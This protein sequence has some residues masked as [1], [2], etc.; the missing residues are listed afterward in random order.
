MDLI[1]L[2]SNPHPDPD[3]FPDDHYQTEF[4]I[5][6]VEDPFPEGALLRVRFPRFGKG[7][8]R[9]S[10]FA[11]QISWIDVKGFIREFV[12]MQHPEALHLWRMVTLAK[13]IEKAEWE[14]TDPP[15]DEFWEILPDSN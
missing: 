6:Q 8:Q 9:R 4:G 15:D 10:D 5:E 14:P 11:A 12:E 7:P 1:R 3:Q 2:D 13:A